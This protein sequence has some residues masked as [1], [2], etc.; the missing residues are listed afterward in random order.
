MVYDKIVEVICE[1]T[2]VDAADLSENSSFDEDLGIDSLD[3]A[4]IIIA[5]E[6]EFGLDEIPENELNKMRTIGD[7]VAYITAHTDEE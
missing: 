5:L 1:Q 6:T 3:V 4:E 2:G 7:L